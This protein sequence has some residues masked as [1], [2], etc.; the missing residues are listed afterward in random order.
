MKNNMKPFF[1]L[2]ALA[3]FSFTTA[4][5]AALTSTGDVELDSATNWDSIVSAPSSGNDT[6][7]IGHNLNIDSTW[8]IG[9]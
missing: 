5:A 9:E 7:S 6:L 3:V 1:I 8:T 2:S 4:Q